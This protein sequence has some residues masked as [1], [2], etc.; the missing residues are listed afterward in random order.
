LYIR[1]ML[2]IREGYPLW[3]PTPSQM[4]PIE[5]RKEGVSIGDFGIVNSDGGFDYIFNIWLPS[6]H[7]AN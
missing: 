5:Y 6:T 2:T 7:P 3:H 1:Q 4:L